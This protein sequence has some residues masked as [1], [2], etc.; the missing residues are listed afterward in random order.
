MSLQN[1]TATSIRKAN[2]KHGNELLRIMDDVMIHLDNTG[3]SEVATMSV[4]DFR[5]I[6]SHIKKLTEKCEW[7]F[8]RMARQLYSDYDDDII[9]A[10][11]VEIEGDYKRFLS[12]KEDAK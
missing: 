7:A 6:Q 10:A 3:F 12:E 1:R 2:E 9:A 4:E 8:S 11:R 5:Y